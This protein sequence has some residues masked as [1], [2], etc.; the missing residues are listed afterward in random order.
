MEVMF[1]M[2]RSFNE[3][4]TGRLQQDQDAFAAANKGQHVDR[5]FSGLFIGIDDSSG[6][7]HEVLREYEWIVG[8]KN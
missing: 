8:Y 1:C 7:L 5:Q 2:M 3:V 4:D 6:I